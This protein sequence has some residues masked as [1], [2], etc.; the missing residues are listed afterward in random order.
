MQ[1][2]R[3]AG[4]KGGS[5]GP[6]AAALV[7]ALQAELAGSRGAAEAAATTSTTASP[8][9]RTW[10]AVCAASRAGYVPLFDRLRVRVEERGESTYLPSVPSVLAGL[11]EA[12]H[13][14]EDDGALVVRLGASLP[15]MLLRK[16]NGAWLYATTDVAAL[17]T[18]LREGL[19]RIVY[20]TDASQALHFRQLFALAERVGWVVAAGGGGHHPSTS[21]SA[22]HRHQLVNALHPRRPPVTL[23]HASFGL[24][25]E[26]ASGRKL[27][28][29][30]G[31]GDAS[32]SALLDAAAGFA[33]E[34]MRGGSGYAAA[35]AAA[36]A[37]PVAADGD[38]GGGKEG[39]V[40]A[41]WQ[42]RKWQSAWGPLPCDFLTCATGGTAPT[43]FHCS[44]PSP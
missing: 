21:S 18:R 43:P 44:G 34:E 31:T 2:K 40:A 35:A 37:V 9:L 3:E 19:Q 6:R 11:V 5:T 23:S 7:S 27:S 15:P 42:W 38:A 26:E 33:L 22:P 17:H 24:V 16:S 12:G 32:L 14:V 41:A 25:T 13:A 30:E 36:A 29:R 10:Q 28:S 8:L 39:A 1:A 4:E 20:V